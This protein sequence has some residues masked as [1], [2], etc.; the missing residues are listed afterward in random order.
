[1]IDTGESLFLFVQEKQPKEHTPLMPPFGQAV[2]W[3]A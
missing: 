2:N 1:M 3:P